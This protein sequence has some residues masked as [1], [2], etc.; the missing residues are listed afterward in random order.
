[1]QEQAVKSHGLGLEGVELDLD[2]LAF[3]DFAPTVN[4]G[5]GFLGFAAVEAAQEFGGVLTRSGLAVRGPGERLDGVAAEK[6]VPVVIEK[7]AGSEDVAPGDVSPVS[8]H[9]ANNALILQA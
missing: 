1:M 6:F 8:N 5:F 2:E 9:H 4:A 3:L 7:I